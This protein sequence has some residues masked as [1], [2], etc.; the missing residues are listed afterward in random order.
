MR[1]RIIGFVVWTFKN[2]TQT[3]RQLDLRKGSR[4]IPEFAVEVRFRAASGDG[5]TFWGDRDGFRCSS[6]EKQQGGD[7]PERSESEQG[8]QPGEDRTAN[9]GD[10]G[11]EA[12]SRWKSWKRGKQ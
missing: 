6:S 12:G 11:A 10:P 5:R 3:R 4:R 9:S 8:R 7:K 1:A 2:A